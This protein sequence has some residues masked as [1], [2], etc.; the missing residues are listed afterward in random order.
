MGKLDV[1]DCRNLRTDNPT[2]MVRIQTFHDGI[3]G[4]PEYTMYPR[5]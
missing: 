1:A 3:R 2:L 4:S 5:C